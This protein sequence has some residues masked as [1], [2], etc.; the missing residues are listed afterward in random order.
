M[1]VAFNI[2]SPTAIIINEQTRSKHQRKFD[3]RFG[4]DIESLQ[5]PYSKTQCWV[6]FLSR[7]EEED[8]RSLRIDI[9]RK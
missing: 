5:L 4:V 8:R 3:A 9:A 7:L 6:N 1:C 2:Y